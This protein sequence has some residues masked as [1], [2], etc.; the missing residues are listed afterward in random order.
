MRYLSFILLITLSVC[1][2]A[3]EAEPSTSYEVEGPAV[4]DFKENTFEHGDI[5]KLNSKWEFY[6]NKLYTYQDFEETT[7]EPDLL[8]QPSS[9]NDLEV[10]GVPCGSFGFATYRIHIQNLP[11][12]E[13]MLNA[14]SLQTASKI[15]INDS[16][17]AEI[18]TVG[19]SSDESDPWNKDVQ[20]IIP[21][22]YESFDLIVQVSNY[23][24]RKGGFIS[25]FEIG[26]PETLVEQH[27]IFYILDTMESAALIIIG[28]FLI[29][30][31]AF[32]R[33]DK[34]ILYFSIFCISLSFR[35]VIAI[36]Y[37]LGTFLPW[38]NWSILIKLEYLGTIVPCLFILLFV[39]Q[40]FPQQLSKLRLKIFIPLFLFMIAVVI[41]APV[42][43]VSWL[44]YPIMLSIAV[45]IIFI[46]IATIKAIIAN[47][48]GATFA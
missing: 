46:S 35:P 37:M 19:T 25:P 40:L 27:Q 22:G 20:I 26:E 34:S 2:F 21:S 36:N 7:I 45:G 28:L 41:F 29:A 6:W 1:S 4:I 23:H 42:W 47:V 10:N 18:G 17:V 43:I 24:H 16:L 31:F 3:Q 32:R 44:T 5:L 38:L 8:V 13:L 9:W 12:K 48:V 39:R 33:K 30:L 14:Y 15:F 11:G